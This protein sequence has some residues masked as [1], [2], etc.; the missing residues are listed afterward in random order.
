MGPTWDVPIHAVAAC[1]LQESW[2][3]EMLKCSDYFVSRIPRRGMP[4]LCIQ[5]VKLNLVHML[6][7]ASVVEVQKL[8][9]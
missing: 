3:N 6:M 7:F 4:I 8:T 5:Q 1:N 2:R 9:S